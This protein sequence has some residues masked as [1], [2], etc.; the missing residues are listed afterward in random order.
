MNKNWDINIK[1]LE[2]EINDT[3]NKS[4][5]GDNFF[6]VS[7]ELKQDILF[8][9]PYL[10]FHISGTVNT[11]MVRDFIRMI[12]EYK[13]CPYY[14]MADILLVNFSSPGGSVPEGMKII[15]IIERF[16]KTDNSGTIICMLANSIIASMGLCIYL[17]GYKR[18]SYENV[19]FMYHQLSTLNYGK[20]HEIENY[21]YYIKR[22]QEK[23][24]SFIIKNSKMNKKEIEKI[25]KDDFYFDAQQALKYGI[26]D[27]VIQYKPHKKEKTGCSNHAKLQ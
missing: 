19:D 26:V 27:D 25:K 23:V 22:L 17:S 7:R 5:V 8:G 16:N 1:E 3:Q 2:K 15:N 13:S 20:T 12:D 6:N 11:T 21:T 9:V 18:L 10:E 24:D 14:G 4:I